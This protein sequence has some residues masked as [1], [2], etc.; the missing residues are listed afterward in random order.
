MRPLSERMRLPRALLA[1]ALLTAPY[2]AAE[3]PPIDVE[4]QATFPSPPFLLEL[5]YVA[6]LM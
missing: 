2:A 6:P 3:G 4:L 5:L 1:C